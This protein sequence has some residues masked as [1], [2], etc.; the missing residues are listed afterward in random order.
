MCIAVFSPI[1]SKCP[2]METLRTCFENNPD[3]GGYAFNDNGMVII[4]KG[5]LDWNSF[6]ES[7][8]KDEKYYNFTSRGVLIHTRIKTHGRKCAE[9]CHPFP[10]DI[11]DDGAM[12]KT[13]YVGNYAAIHNGIISLTSSE[14]Y[15]EPN[16]SDTLVFCR[17][18]MPKIAGN[19]AWFKRKCNI[20]LIEKLIG[21]KMAILNGRG[22]IIHTSGFTEDNGNWYSNTSYKTPR[23]RTYSTHTTYN[24]TPYSWDDDDSDYYTRGYGYGSGYADGYG[25]GSG[26]CSYYQNGVKNNYSGGTNSTSYK[27]VPLMRCSIGDT[28]MGDSIEDDC[29]TNGERGF[30]LSEEG[31][32]YELVKENGAQD[33]DSEKSFGFSFLGSGQFLDKNGKKKD[34]KANFWP[35]EGQFLGESYPDC[36][37][38]MYTDGDYPPDDDDMP[39]DLMVDLDEEDF[40]NSGTNSVKK[41]TV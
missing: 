1:G 8:S 22:E 11:E 20:S 23:V 29:D 14:A 33:D 6:W 7:F 13:Y 10:I 18:Y 27:T 3:G 25:Y 34:F 39:L 36:I 17:D 4:K 21:S 32:L 31:F 16:S 40:A 35:K 28:I 2:D 24:Y 15:R 12:R 26:T 9:L 5:F 30:A 37:R 41:N 38:D 19:K